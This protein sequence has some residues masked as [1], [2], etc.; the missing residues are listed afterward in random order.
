MGLGDAERKSGRIK[1]FGISE[2]V[3]LAHLKDS[4][5]VLLTCLL[6]GFGAW[7]Y[8]LPEAL[9][10]QPMACCS[11]EY[12]T[13]I[14][15]ALSMDVCPLRNLGFVCTHDNQFHDLIM[16]TFTEPELFDPLR[17]KPDSRTVSFAVMVGVIVLSLA[18]GESFTDV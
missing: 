18:L 14:K 7:W 13:A 8:L 16:E 3:V 10:T 15:D 6:V 2:A 12:A 11:A 9:L 4:R 5:F 1:P 17:L